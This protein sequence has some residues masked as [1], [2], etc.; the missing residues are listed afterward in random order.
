MDHHILLNTPTLE[1]FQYV[2]Q[3]AKRRG[4]AALNDFHIQSQ[5]Q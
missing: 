1:V 3:L 4:G 2:I 5:S